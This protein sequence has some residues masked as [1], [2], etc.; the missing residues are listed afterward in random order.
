MFTPSGA[1]WRAK[2]LADA[3]QAFNGIL[4]DMITSYLNQ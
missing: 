4:R 3:R 2:A 1:H